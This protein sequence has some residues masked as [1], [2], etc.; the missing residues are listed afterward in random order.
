MKKFFLF[1]F[2]LIIFCFSFFCF[3][4]ALAKTLQFSPNVSLGPFKAGQSVSVPGD[5][6]FLKE[7]IIAIYKFIIGLSAILAVI[8]IAIGGIIWA[9]AAGSAG[10]VSKAKGLITGSLFGLVLTLLS[11]SL[12]SAVNSDITNLRFGKTMSDVSNEAVKGCKWQKDK[13]F[14]FQNDYTDSGDMFCGAKNNNDDKYCCCGAG[15]LE[16][17]E[18]EKCSALGDQWNLYGGITASSDYL[19][20][21][22]NFCAEWNLGSALEYQLEKIDGGVNFLCCKCSYKA[23]YTKNINYITCESNADCKMMNPPG[24]IEYTCWIKSKFGNNICLKCLSKGLKCEDNS[25]CC[26]GTCSLT[27]SGEKECQ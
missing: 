8:V 26:S 9:T 4:F 17:A 10:Q 5:F 2:F 7:Y 12:L 23:T 24:K 6:T 19:N 22:K 11:Y 15:T 3:H 16:E 25:Q 18:R 13:C 27:S 14:T 1:S 20:Y 21:C